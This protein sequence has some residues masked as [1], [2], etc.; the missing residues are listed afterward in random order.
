[1]AR[2]ATTIPDE[3]Y[4]ALNEISEKTGKPMALMVREALEMY[5]AAQ[6]INIETKVDWGG[7]RRKG[8]A[9]DGENE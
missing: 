6:G 7:N 4:K 9:E 1:M 8:K 5:L 2:L 3:A